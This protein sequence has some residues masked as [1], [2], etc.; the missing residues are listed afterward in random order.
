MWKKQTNKK[1]NVYGGETKQSDKEIYFKTSVHFNS[2]TY[3]SLTNLGRFQMFWKNCS[4]FNTQAKIWLT[5]KSYRMQTVDKLYVRV[6][7]QTIWV[8]LLFQ[9]REVGLTSCF[10]ILFSFFH[11]LHTSVCLLLNTTRNIL[12]IRFYSD[13]WISLW[14]TFVVP[15]YWT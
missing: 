11:V 3:N 4:S 9:F 5:V 10:A 6:C 15:S 7:F 2:K 12:H 14:S 1:Q 13:T 8:Q